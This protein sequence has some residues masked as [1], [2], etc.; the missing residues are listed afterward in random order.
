VLI[1]ESLGERNEA[2]TI[3]IDFS[4]PLA[5]GRF[6]VLHNEQIASFSA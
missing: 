2:A 6:L 3:R 1:R 4:G 5:V